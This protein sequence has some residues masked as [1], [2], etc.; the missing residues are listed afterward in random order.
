MP[1]KYKCV[2]EI[3]LKY[4]QNII[5]KLVKGSDGTERLY[6][7][8]KM[9]ARTA[10]LEG[11][12]II[13]AVTPSVGA[14]LDSM[15]AKH[16]REALFE[17]GYDHTF[18]AMLQL[19][20]ENITDEHFE[21]LTGKLL[22]SLML[23]DKEIEDLDEHFDKY[24]GDFIELLLWLGKENFANFILGN[25]TLVSSMNRLISLVSPKI[26]ESLESLKNVMNEPSTE[27]KQE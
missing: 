8:R 18:G 15:A 10:A 3:T 27:T 12:K 4:S 16:N 24:A 20:S 11:F 26:K 9:S 7:A 17:D 25:A 5:S 1:N 6:K 2:K 23:G 13:K 22:G 21:D 14:G 19:L